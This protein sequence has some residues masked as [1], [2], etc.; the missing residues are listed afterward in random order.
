M[1]KSL[2]SLILVL[3]LAFTVTAE[4]VHFV[5][6]KYSSVTQPRASDVDLSFSDSKVTIKSI[7]L[8]KRSPPVFKEIAYSS[9]DEMSY[10]L[11]TRHR[12]QE[13]AMLMVVSLG[14]GGIVMATK[15]K[16]HWLAITSHTGEA[17][18]VTVLRL[19]RSEF[20]GVLAAAEAKSGKKIVRLAAKNSAMDPTLKSKDMDEVVPFSAEKVAAALKTAMEH[21][22]CNVSEEAGD[23]IECKRA[24]GASGQSGTGGESVTARLEASGE[25]TRVRVVTGK[26]VAG[27]V[28]KRNWSTPIYQEMMKA[29]Q[30]T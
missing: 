8:D 29:L 7:K 19:D 20:E 25:G 21:E 9:I 11:A 26:G 28:G 2:R 5:K 3:T 16:Q 18:E 22:G 4:D 23:H 12:I 1:S 15:E 17:K 13:G 6:T 24:R 27:R 30:K 14:V 10:E